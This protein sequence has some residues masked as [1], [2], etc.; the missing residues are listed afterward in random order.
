MARGTLIHAWFEEIHWLDQ[1]VNAD[2][3][4]RIARHTELFGQDPEQLLAEFLN[5]IKAPGLSEL[6]TEARYRDSLPHALSKE[7]GLRQADLEVYNERRFAVHV[8]NS[9]LSGTIDRLVLFRVAGKPAAAD[10]VDFKT[11]AVNDAPQDV[12]RLVEHY[13]PQLRAYRRAVEAI[14]G[15]PADRTTARLF[16]MGLDRVVSAGTA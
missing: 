2:E 6:L 16:L 15:I 8:D 14:F 7:Q 9:I 1:P 11:D 4:R 3:L 10:I 12:E 13:A 5:S